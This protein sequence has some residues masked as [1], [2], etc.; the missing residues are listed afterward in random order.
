MLVLLNGEITIGLS[1]LDS[2]GIN[3]KLNRYTNVK[4]MRHNFRCNYLLPCIF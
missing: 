1:R 4:G 3:R 2:L